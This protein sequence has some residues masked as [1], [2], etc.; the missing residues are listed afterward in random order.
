MTP[1][2]AVHRI[3]SG[4]SSPAGPARGPGRRRPVAALTLAAALT[5]LGGCAD[6]AGAGSP[7]ATTAPPASPDPSPTADPTTTPTSDPAPAEP[8]ALHV[9]GAIGDHGVDAPESVVVPYLTGLWGAEP[10]VADGATA[11]VTS[12]LP[13]RRL[14]WDG[15][16]V[17]VR[18]TDAAGAAT[19]P[20][21]AG[22]V[23]DGAGES[24]LGPLTTAEGLGLGDPEDAV[25]AAYPDAQSFDTPEPGRSLWALGA[26]T[27]D[28]HLDDLTVH[29]SDGVVTALHGG[30]GC[31][32]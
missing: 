2:T 22:W 8:P 9:G 19:D 32:D 20:Y 15:L 21:V 24:P 30:L 16:T 18:T 29:A 12:G 31:G 6:V 13:G 5:V 25:V 10:E 4:R 17:L 26:A 7:G 28:T 1:P 3:A 23:L 11:C 14:S 27:V